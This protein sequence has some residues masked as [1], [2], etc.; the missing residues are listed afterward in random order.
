MVPFSYRADLASPRHLFIPPSLLCL[1]PTSNY[2]DNGETLDLFYYFYFFLTYLFIPTVLSFVRVISIR[3]TPL[4][5]H[6]PF[7][8]PRQIRFRFVVE[9]IS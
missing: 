8:L 1:I 9:L 3:E 7:P 4:P 5:G 6:S 2:R